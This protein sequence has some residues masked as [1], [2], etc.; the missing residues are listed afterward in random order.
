VGPTPTRILLVE[1]NIDDVE[2]LRRFIRRVPGSYQVDIAYDAD[3]AISKAS[4]GA[5]DLALVDHQLPGASGHELI[6]T[7]REAVPELPIV[8][9]TGHGDE[10]LAVEV[11]KAGA[12]DYLRKHDLDPSILA[13]VVRNVLER[14][15]LENEVR[16]VNERLREW[17]I[18]DGLTGLYNHRHFQE[19]LRTE[20]ARARR[21]G[22]PLA[23]LMLDLDHFK[24]VNDTYGHPFGDRVLKRLAATL[25][26]VA[27]E[28]DI[29]AR[30]GGEEFVVVLPNTDREGAR[31]LAERVRSSVSENTLAFE[32]E[33]V[34]TTVSIGVATHHDPGVEDEQDLVKR[35]DAALYRAKHNGRDQVCV[36]DGEGVETMTTPPPPRRQAP[37]GELRRRFLEGVTAMLE[38]AEGRADDHRQHSQRVAELATRFGRALG[39]DRDRLETLYTGALL[40]DVGRIGVSDLIWLKTGPL[41]PL[42]REKV[43]LHTVLGAE[44]LERFEIGASERAIVRHHHERWDGGGYPDGLAGRA[45]PELARVVAV[46]D[47]YDA[48]TSSR[49]WRPARSAAEAIAVLEDA[50]GTVYDPDLV[51][52][53]V[54]LV[55]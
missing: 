9:L 33:G 47:G 46:L 7:M 17:A 50:A 1:D 16:Q 25:T 31:R 8:M 14:S 10:K 51:R 45:I 27:R 49:P 4:Q 53:F 55:G 48:L 19:L 2:V 29:I 36:A 18:R 40:H 30:Y 34:T 41:D 42:E 21:Y 28:V 11:M 13:R 35:A 44:M 23:C 39:Y 37:D 20:M 24:D 12:Y 54:A 52:A 22:Q 3:E 32:G 6:G 15:R 26:D 38:M 43:R 5:Y